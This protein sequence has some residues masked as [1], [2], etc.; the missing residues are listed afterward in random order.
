MGI[1]NKLRGCT[2]HQY[3]EVSGREREANGGRTHID[4]G[5]PKIPALGLRIPAESLEVQLETAEINGA[6]IARRSRRLTFDVTS[7]ERH[8]GGRNDRMITPPREQSYAQGGHPLDGLHDQV[9]SM[10]YVE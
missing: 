7:G 8:G 9:L 10:S 6:L 4:V 2:V 3:I 1:M 5:C